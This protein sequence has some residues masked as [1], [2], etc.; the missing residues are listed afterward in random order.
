[1]RRIGGLAFTWLA[2]CGGTT[3]TTIANTHD[4]CAPLA[5]VSTTANDAQLEGMRAAEALWRDHGAPAMGL[6]SDATVEVRFEAAAPPFH[7]IYEDKAGVIY[8]NSDLV[9]PELSI[10]I[11]HEVGHVF[12]LVHVPVDERVSLMNPGNLT[13]PP[14]AE[15]QAALA[16]LW[17]TCN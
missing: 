8:I 4:A 15:D 5:L 3:D 11:A 13:S 7:G 17:G 16:A 10:V 1:L 6:R 14:T 2:A 9:E 12:G